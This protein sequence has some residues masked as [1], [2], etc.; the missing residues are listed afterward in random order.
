MVRGGAGGRLCR[1]QVE[2]AAF[3]QA[4]EDDIL[5]FKSRTP[6]RPAEV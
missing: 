1:L 2:V 6:L 3:A 4:G 5:T